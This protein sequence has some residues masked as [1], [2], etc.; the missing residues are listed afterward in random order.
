[1]MAFVDDRCKKMLVA[2]EYH[3]VMG[4]V[5]KYK[6]QEEDVEGLVNN[7]LL[8]LDTPRKAILLRDVRAMVIPYD[9][10]RFDAMI[11][12]S[13]VEALE[14]YGNKAPASP[15]V[16]VSAVTTKPKKTLVE[17][18]QDSRGNFQ[19][20]TRSEAEQIKKTREE[21]KKERLAL[22]CQGSSILER[23][24]MKKEEDKNWLNAVDSSNQNSF[25][26]GPTIQVIDVSTDSP[27]LSTFGVPSSQPLAPDLPAVEV[28]D[29]SVTNQ[30]S[31][32]NGSFLTIPDR[33]TA[34]YRDDDNEEKSKNYISF[35]LPKI[36]TSM[37]ISISGGSGSRAQPEIRIE[38]V[39][40]GG[41]AAD[42]G[43]LQSGWEL[44]SIDDESL[45]GVSHAEAV[46]IIRR[47]YNDKSRSVM[48]IVYVQN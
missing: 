43:T 44:I 17:A 42:D 5:K 9:L 32:G 29:T 27:R 28:T 8:T 1:M 13:E 24:A 15:V 37:G 14:F 26:M 35:D 12:S 30:H 45:Q 38:K 46:D 7:L 41:A 48:H 6:E 4:H 19:L 36:R 31:N 20:R 2:D 10:G 40:P 39:F 21:L 3:T 11:S 34:E 33:V 25:Q 18:V 16:E 22:K 47:A 23:E